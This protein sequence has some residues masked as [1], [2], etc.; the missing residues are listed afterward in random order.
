MRETHTTEVERPS[1]R[2]FSVGFVLVVHIVANNVRPP[3]EEIAKTPWPRRYVRCTQRA[4]ARG[5]P[6]AVAGLWISKAIPTVVSGGGRRGRRGGRRDLDDDGAGLLVV[7]ALP[8][9]VIGGRVEEV[10][11]VGDRSNEDQE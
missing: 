2:P 6:G 10:R 3:H 8:L 9:W 5:P 4:A 7:E 11:A 1:L